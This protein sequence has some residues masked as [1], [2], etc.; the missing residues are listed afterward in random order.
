MQAGAAAF[1][2]GGASSRLKREVK[3]MRS[4][5]QTLP[6]IAALLLAGCG[7]GYNF[8]PRSVDCNDLA[9]YNLCHFNPAV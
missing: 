4:L 7:A 1:A 5:R 2:S 9:N 6:L 8:N 3:A